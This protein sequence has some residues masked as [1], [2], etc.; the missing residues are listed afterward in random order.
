MATLRAFYGAMGWRERPGS[1]DDFA[2][3]ETGTVILALYPIDRLGHEAAPDERGPVAPGWNGITVGV[4]VESPQ[5]VDQTFEA[6]VAAGATAIASPVKREWGGYSGYVA[7]PDGNRWEI[8][9]APQA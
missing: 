1:N 8:T 2:T 3:F 5:D 7:D 4:N 9:W 6:S